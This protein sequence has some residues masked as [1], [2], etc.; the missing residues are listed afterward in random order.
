MNKLEVHILA[1]ESNALEPNLAL[2]QDLA[3]LC[4]ANYRCVPAYWISSKCG[5]YSHNFLADKA[6]DERIDIF[7]VSLVRDYKRGKRPFLIIPNLIQDI[8]DCSQN[9][10]NLWG[11]VLYGLSDGIGR[12]GVQCEFNLHSIGFGCLQAAE[13]DMAN[14]VAR[15]LGLGINARIPEGGIKKLEFGTKEAIVLEEN[16]IANAIM[17]DLIDRCASRGVIVCDRNKIMK[18]IVSYIKHW[19]SMGVLPRI[20]VDEKF[21]DNLTDKLIDYIMINSTFT[22]TARRG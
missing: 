16:L 2:G 10:Y 18:F 9:P 15:L 17:G 1:G 3:D 4:G 22:S 20:P 7:S 21:M 11:S 12:C 19:S 8:S 13:S 14:L 6:D 5:K